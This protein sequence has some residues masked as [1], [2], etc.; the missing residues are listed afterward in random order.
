[1]TYDDAVEELRFLLCGPGLEA[2]GVLEAALDDE[3]LD[4]V[5]R[6]EVVYALHGEL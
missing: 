5:L 6:H 3:A 2:L 4:G 1:M